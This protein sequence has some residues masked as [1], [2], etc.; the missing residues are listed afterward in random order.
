MLNILDLF[1][2]NLEVIKLKI[3]IIVIDKGF[4]QQQE[5]NLKMHK[6]AGY[7]AQWF[8]VCLTY[9]RPWVQSPVPQKK[10]KKTEKNA[11]TPHLQGQ[12]NFMQSN[13]HSANFSFKT[14]YRFFICSY[15]VE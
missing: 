11:Q 9:M 10:K 6:W 15:K 8:N 14:F 13:W 1:W 5:V 3:E 7:I 4:Q 2:E 12:D